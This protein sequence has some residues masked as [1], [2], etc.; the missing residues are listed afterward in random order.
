MRSLILALCFISVNLVSAQGFKTCAE[1]GFFGGGSY[2]VGDL[3]RTRHFVDSKLAGGLIFRYNLSTR[4]SLRFTANY[5][6]VFAFDAESKSSDQVNRNLSFKS[7]IIELA[8]GFEIDI[9]KYRINDMKYPFTPYF[10]YQLAYTRIN[11]KAEINGNEVALQPL[12]TEG[13]GTGIPGTKSRRYNLNQFTV[14]LGIGFKFNLRKRV[15]ISIEYGIRKTFTDYLDDVSGNYLDPD[16]LAAS[17]GPLS[18]D[19]ADRS[20]NGMGTAG[21]NRGNSGN[22]DWYSFYGIMLTFK[23]FKKNICDMRGW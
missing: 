1:M 8:A 22:K 11:P 7:R 21:M 15:A 6:N 10:F 4:H 18:A 13:Q 20:L 12:G 3:N 16:I 5:G 23:P 2:Y 9:L 19:L 17:N 14:P